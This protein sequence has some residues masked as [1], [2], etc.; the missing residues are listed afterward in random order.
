MTEEEY[1][2][3]Q[4]RYDGQLVEQV[5]LTPEQVQSMTL[6]E[7]MAATRQYRGVHV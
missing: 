4:E 1:L 5:G 7:K 3:R 2:S 6:Q